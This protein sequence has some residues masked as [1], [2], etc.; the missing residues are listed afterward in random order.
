MSLSFA[1]VLL[2]TSACALLA[3]TNPN[4]LLLFLGA[5]M[6]IFFLYKVVLSDIF[7]WINLSGVMRFVTAIIFRFSTKILVNFTMLVQLRNPC[8][9]GGLLFLVSILMS[10]VGR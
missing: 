9:V 3:L 10:V 6:G 8:E 7:Y 1:H 4:W 2:L 5:D